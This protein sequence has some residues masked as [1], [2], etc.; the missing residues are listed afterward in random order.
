[1]GEFGIII[2]RHRVEYA[3]EDEEG[4]SARCTLVVRCIW[5]A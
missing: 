2:K 4:G 5:R 3:L 1:M